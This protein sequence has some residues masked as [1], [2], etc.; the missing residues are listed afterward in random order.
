MIKYTFSGHE[1]FQCK[2]LWLKKGY[3]FV[4]SRM[5]FS[6]ENSIVELGVGKNMVS[7]IKYWMK[8]FGLLDS[9]NNL[10]PL[11]DW[12]FATETG[13]DPFLENVGTIWLLHYSLI[14]SKNASI[15]S[16]TFDEFQKERTEFS[17]EQLFGFIRRKYIET[18]NKAVLNEKTVMTDIGVLL[19]NYVKP[20][21]KSKVLEEFSTLLL[22]LNVIYKTLKGGYG[23]NYQ[24]K[25]PLPPDILCYVILDFFEG[26]VA[27]DYNDILDVSRWFCMLPNEVLAAIQEI[28]T[29]YPSV[30]YDENSGIK[31]V[32]LKGKLDKWAVL[33][34]YYLNQ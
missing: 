8:S 16:L 10:T 9:D 2:N 3:D 33:S 15:Y 28:S 24:N 11:A 14:K 27:I 30:V 18:G 13:Y 29:K 17:K 26:Q 12:L 34:N 32:Q 19:K 7:S 21:L 5:S 31:Q 23:F 20:E 4:K 25:L 1:T 6:D 22:D